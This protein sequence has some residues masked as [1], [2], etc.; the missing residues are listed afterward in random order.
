MYTPEEAWNKAIDAAQTDAA[1]VADRAGKVRTIDEA[2]K[3][4]DTAAF[5]ANHHAA[6]LSA[7]GTNYAIS[8]LAG[9]GSSN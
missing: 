1:I 5:A 4:A 6:Q 3:L 7:T 2:Q 9:L 8:N